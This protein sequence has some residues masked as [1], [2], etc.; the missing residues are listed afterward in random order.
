MKAV[1]TL[2]LTTALTAGMTGVASAADYS[3]DIHK[4]DF[5]WMQFN[6]MYALDEKP[7]AVDAATGHDYLE[8]EFGGRS[9]IF[10]L[11][12][13][14]DVFNPSERE[15]SGKYQKQ[16]MFMKFAPKV[17]LDALTGKD[18]SFG[19]VKEIY[20]ST[21][22]NWDGGANNDTSY[23]V[24]NSFWGVG[25]DVEVPW[26]GKTAM[27]LYGLYDLNTKDWNGYQFSANWFKP[28]YNFDN[29]SFVSFQGYVD[30][31]FGADT[32]RDDEGVKTNSSNGGAAFFGLFWHSEQ[33]ALGYGLKAYSDVYLI[34]DTADFESTGVSHYFSA[35]YK[36]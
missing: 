17:S 33:F 3:D 27:N 35:S 6:Y 11:Y 9:G 4:N 16:K 15:S 29:G 22:F 12:G 5:S 19:P 7:R 28:V 8:M 18:L 13:Y 21:L 14:V 31:Q 10:N 30:W 32:V 25:A 1:K 20:F 2:A 23:A 34:A 36:F 26:L 24:N